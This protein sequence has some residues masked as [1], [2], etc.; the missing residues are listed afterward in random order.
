MSMSTN[1]HPSPNAA[2][3][4]DLPLRCQ[5]AMWSGSGMPAGLCDEPAYGHATGRFAYVGIACPRHGGPRPARTAVCATHDVKVRDDSGH[6]YCPDCESPTPA[7][8]Q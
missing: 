5:K 6:W 8:R 4:Q 7:V 3:E 2:N 1:T